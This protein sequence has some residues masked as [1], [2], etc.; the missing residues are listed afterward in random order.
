MKHAF[1][2]AEN[3]SRLQ[4]PCDVFIYL[5]IV[6]TKIIT[7][8]SLRNLDGG[9]RLFSASV[10]TTSSIKRRQESAGR[11]LEQAHCGP[12]GA[13]GLLC[14]QGAGFVFPAN[15]LLGLGCSCPHLPSGDGVT[16]PSRGRRRPL[17]AL[18]LGS[19]FRI[20]FVQLATVVDVDTVYD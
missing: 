15:V 10:V 3:G 12:A 4:T 20:I 8:L 9:A 13:L 17:P 6:H 1:N 16:L 2:Y 7:N 14:D 11:Y 5:V 19:C 18:L